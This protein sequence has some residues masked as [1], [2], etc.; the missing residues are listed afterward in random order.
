MEA[1]G[2]THGAPG[3]T[4]DIVS[5][6][7]GETPRASSPRPRVAAAGRPAILS[8]RDL[9]KRYPTAGGGLTVLEG[10][11]VD[12]YPGELVAIVGE[13]GTGKSTLLHLLGALDRPT[14]GTVTYRGEDVFA[15]GDEALAAFRNR[16]IGFVFQFHHLLPEFTAIENVSMPAL[17]AGGTFDTARARARELLTMLGLAERMDHRPSQLSGGEQQRVAVARALMNE[18]GLVLMDEPSGNLDTKTAETLHDELLRLSRDADQAFVV[19]THNPALAG[20]ADRVLRLEGGRLVEERGGR[21]E[22]R[23]PG[24]A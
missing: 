17:I 9:Q 1:S 12:V 23:A 24:T 20:L 3:S 7:V 22:E 16:A 2:K 13:S 4:S 15:K 21:V 14:A 5:A 6:E 11:D 8:G 18:P 10:L 19:V